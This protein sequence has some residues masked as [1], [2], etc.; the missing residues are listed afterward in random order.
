M[1][2]TP[3]QQWNPA[4]Y[5]QNAR[6][7]ANLGT[8]VLELLAPQVGERILDLGCGDG[9]LT[10]QLQDV[11]CDVVG[12]DASPDMVVATQALGV[13]AL[14]MNGA[15]LSFE[16]NEF[17][18]VFTNAALHWIKQP[19]AVISGVYHCLK[20]G[21]RFVGEFGGQGNVAKILRALISAL[22]SRRLQVESPWFFSSV[23]DYRQLLES[24]GFSVQSIALIPRPTPL[25]GDV[26]GWLKTFA[27]PYIAALPVPERQPFIGEVVETLRP[28]LCDTDG[29]WTA[30]YVR[31]RFS[32]TKS[33]G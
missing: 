8:P 22:A 5:A 18:A 10:Q 15:S 23:N 27:Q 4:Q 28:E 11:G 7:V 12:V 16:E 33:V 24:G 1:D 32:A 9:V 3:N 2:T 20:P 31:L 26:G 21:G 29:H 25:P 13:P 14:V 30:D 6:Y 17:D 19:E